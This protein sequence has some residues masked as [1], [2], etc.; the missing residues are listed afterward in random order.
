MPGMMNEN[1]ATGEKRAVKHKSVLPLAFFAVNEG[2]SGSF[3]VFK[4]FFLPGGYG[5]AA[6]FQAVFLDV[7]V[8]GAVIDFVLQA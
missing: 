2:L 4:F 1:A 6:Q 3:P 8:K 5:F 7:S